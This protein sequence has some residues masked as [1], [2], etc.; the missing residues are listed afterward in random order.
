MLC[1]HHEST[2]S[3]F[4]PARAQGHGLLVALHYGLLP[5]MAVASIMEIHTWAIQ[6]FYLDVKCVPSTHFVPLPVL[7]P[8]DFIGQNKLLCHT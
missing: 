6:S 2:G 4:L 7:V 3:S 5:V 8:V 1:D